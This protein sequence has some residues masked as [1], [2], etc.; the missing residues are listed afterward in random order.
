MS[1]G[2]FAT[3]ENDKKP[4]VSY[5]AKDEAEFVTKIVLTRKTEHGKNYSNYIIAIPKRVAEYLNLNETYLIKVK[6]SE[7]KKLEKETTKTV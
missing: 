3:A 1:I 4:Q 2:R 6:L 5:M 7:A